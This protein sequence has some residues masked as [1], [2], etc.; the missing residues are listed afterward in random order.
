[1]LHSF[2]FINPGKDAHSVVFIKSWQPW[3]H[4]ALPNPSHYLGDLAISV[5]L[6]HEIRLIAYT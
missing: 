3:P 5:F 2:P 1:M 6:H 4:L